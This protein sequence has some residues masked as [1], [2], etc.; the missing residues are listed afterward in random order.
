MDVLRKELNDFYAGQELEKE[1]LDR[2]LLHDCIDRVRAVTSIDNDCRVITDASADRCYIVGGKLACLLGLNDSFPALDVITDSSDE[3]IIYNRIH[4]EDLVDKRMLEYH[5][6]KFID[7][8][9]DCEKLNYKAICRF[10]MRN[11]DGEYVYIDNSTQALHLSP[12]GKVWLILCC[13]NLS[14]YPNAGT[15]ISP[16]I[17]NMASGDISDVPLDG[18]RTAILSTREKEILRLIS[19][20]KLS[21]EI[22][23]ILGIS[24][25]TVNRHRQNILGKLCVDNSMEAVMA[26]VSMK[27]L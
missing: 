22:A 16:R 3:D 12:R 7:S 14:S 9:P 15:G 18:K 4:P 10:R 25:N 17:V 26:A 20:G 24:I 21:K 6:F 2:K 23:L 19:E 8:Q 5:F 11:R 1:T 27:L 13:Y